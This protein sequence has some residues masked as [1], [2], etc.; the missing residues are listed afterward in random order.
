MTKR[1]YCK[2][3]RKTTEHIER[4]FEYHNRRHECKEC[5]YE[6]WDGKTAW[7]APIK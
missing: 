1:L 4:G 5:G 3:C 7:D 2:K 6:E